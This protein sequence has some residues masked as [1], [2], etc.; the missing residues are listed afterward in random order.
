MTYSEIQAMLETVLPGHVHRHSA[1]AEDARCIAWGETGFRLARGDNRPRLAALK[2]TVML[3]TQADDDPALLELL[4]VLG[5]NRVAFTDPSTS[6]DE[7]AAA[8]IHSMDCE[9]RYG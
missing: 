7:A 2:F 8:L 4:R 3:V 1:P 9:A 6:F 5:E